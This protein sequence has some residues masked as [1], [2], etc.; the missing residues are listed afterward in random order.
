MRHRALRILL[1]ALIAAWFG[2]VVPL[3]PR[4]IVKLPG[5]CD[6]AYG[7][8]CCKNG[9]SPVDSKKAADPNCAICFFV[10][11][12]DLPVAMGMDVPELGLAGKAL[13]WVTVEATL[14]SRFDPTCERGPPAA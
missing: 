3:H 11:T 10:L 2:V 13:A 8:V 12:L 6:G 1:L 5:A 14:A 9:K 7:K 4:G